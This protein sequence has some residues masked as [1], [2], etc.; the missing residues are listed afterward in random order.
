MKRLKIAVTLST[1]LAAL[2]L[3]LWAVAQPPRWSELASY[4]TSL[5]GRTSAQAHNATLAAQALD[6]KTLQPGAEFSFNRAVGSWTADRGYVKA[7]VSYSGELIPSWGGGVCQTST[8]LYNA[9]LLAGLE[10]AERHRH[11]FTP[12]YAPPGQD[13]AVAQFDVDFR[14]RNPYPWPIRIDTDAEGDSIICRILSQSSPEARFTVEREIRQVTPAS[15]VI[16][17]HKRAS[18]DAV[19]WRVI[20]HG[21]PGVRVAVYRREIMGTRSIR[22]LISEDTYPPMNRL[23]S[24]E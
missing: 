7:P 16:R 12:H 10:I 21:A 8:T 9:A 14:F 18:G 20:N 19:R 24:G 5:N 2:A 13:A 15:E 1:A 23:V 3:A 4:R 6:G 17:M 22:R 11:Q